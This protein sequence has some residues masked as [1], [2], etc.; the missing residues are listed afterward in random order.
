MRLNLYCF[1]CKNGTS[2][3][4][5]VNDEGYYMGACPKGHA[6]R[7]LCDQPL[8]EILFEIGVNAILD[9]YNREAVSSF[10]SSLERFYEYYVSVLTLKNKI[11]PSQ[12]ENAWNSVSAQSERQLGGFIFAYL[13]ETGRAPSLLPNLQVSFRNK[14]IHKGHIPSQVNAI[15]FGQAVLNVINPIVKDLKEN[16]AEQIGQLHMTN[17]QDIKEKF[18]NANAY[19]SIVT[20]IHMKSD[21]RIEYTMEKALEK[22][23]AI[24]TEKEDR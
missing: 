5:D 2:V 22:L 12:F 17:Q 9:G 3:N 21:S 24:R 10:A 11:D 1:E 20:I 18:G 14:V 6:L 4:V 15:A 7:Y 23:S 13:M 8:F 19:I 16:Y